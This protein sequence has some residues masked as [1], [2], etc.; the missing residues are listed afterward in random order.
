MT[1]QAGYQPLEPIRM[2]PLYSWPPRPVAT[3][4]WIATGLLF[5]WGL[6]FIGLAVL[7]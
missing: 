2:P 4:R 1:A 5:P 6:L 3:L 7:S